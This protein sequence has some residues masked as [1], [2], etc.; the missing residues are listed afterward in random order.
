ME[1]RLVLLDRALF[2]IADY[3]DYLISLMIDGCSGWM[4]L[5]DLSD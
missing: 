3:A 2:V 5:M 4:P 1:Y